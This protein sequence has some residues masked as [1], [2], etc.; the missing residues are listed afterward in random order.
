[1]HI[2]IFSYNI[3]LIFMP[4]PPLSKKEGP[5]ALYIYVHWSV[6]RS[7][8]PCAVLCPKSFKL[9]HDPCWYSGSRSKVKLFLMCWKKE[10]AYVYCKHFLLFNVCWELFDRDITD[11][12]QF[13]TTLFLCHLC[14]AKQYKG[15]H[16]V[17]VCLV[18]T[19]FT[20]K[21]TAG[22]IHPS[23]NISFLSFSIRTD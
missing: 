21:L 18:I 9:L 20:I 5:I 8:A 16:F 4:P 17:H 3:Q 15:D 7:P 10:G 6:C 19:L 23:N 22:L 1:M 12:L 11:I 14:L 13:E 2:E